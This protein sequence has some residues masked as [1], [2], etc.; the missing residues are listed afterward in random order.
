MTK[1]EAVNFIEENALQ[2]YGGSAIL[3]IEDVYELINTIYG[4]LDNE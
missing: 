4:D 2:D 1:Q 3:V